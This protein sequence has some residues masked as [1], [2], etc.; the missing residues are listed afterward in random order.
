MNPHTILTTPFINNKTTKAQQ[1]YPNPKYEEFD[2][3]S[4]TA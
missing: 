1:V 4:L 2:A 3:V